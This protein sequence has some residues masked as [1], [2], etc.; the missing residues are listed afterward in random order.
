MGTTAKK[1]VNANQ[2][3]LSKISNDAKM[4]MK[5]LGAVRSFLLENSDK[6]D[7][8]AYEVNALQRTKTNPDFYEKLKGACQHSDDD[9]TKTCV[10][11][12]VRTLAKWNKDGVKIPAKAVVK[13]PTKGAK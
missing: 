11:W 9:R 5:S 13:K 4:L 12:V 2:A 7:L 8:T 3:R 10:Y 6:L 1:T